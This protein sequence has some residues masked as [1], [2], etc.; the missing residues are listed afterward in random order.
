MG[1]QRLAGVSGVE[2]VQLGFDDGGDHLHQFSEGTRL[3]AVGH[4][5]QAT[6]EALKRK[7]ISLRSR[8]NMTAEL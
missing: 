3:H 2:Q 7:R 1:Q 6:F 8:T 5:D 4:W